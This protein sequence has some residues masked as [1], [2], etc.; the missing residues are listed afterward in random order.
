MAGVVFYE[1]GDVPCFGAR[2]AVEPGNAFAIPHRDLVRY[3]GNNQ[4][5]ILEV[6]GGD[7]KER[8]EVAIAAC[9]TIPPTRKQKLMAIINGE[10]I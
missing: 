3:A 6:L 7:F 1:P 8:L 10:P 4:L 5:E 2:T 9:K